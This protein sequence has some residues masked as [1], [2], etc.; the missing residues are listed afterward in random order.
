MEKHIPAKNWLQRK[1]S[2]GNKLITDNKLTAHKAFVMKKK[3][4]AW[5][6]AL[7]F[8]DDFERATVEMIIQAKTSEQRNTP[9]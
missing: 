4:E 1:I 8:I 2:D 5:E 9:A 6:E 7:T 3:I